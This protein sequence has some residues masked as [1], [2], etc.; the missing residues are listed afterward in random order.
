VTQEQANPLDSRNAGKPWTDGELTRFRNLCTGATPLRLIV[1]ELGRP[2]AE[3]AAK[4]A[5]LGI[6]LQTTQ[7]ISRF[8]FYDRR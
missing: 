1:R 6:E 8:T 2:E 4:A 3:L 5:E 7:D